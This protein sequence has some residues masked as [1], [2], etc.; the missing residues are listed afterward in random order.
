VLTES[1]ENLDEPEAKGTVQGLIPLYVCVAACFLCAL[2]PPRCALTHPLRYHS[3]DDLDSGRVC[4]P[5]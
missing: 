4:R 1:L 5:H 3:I 2:I